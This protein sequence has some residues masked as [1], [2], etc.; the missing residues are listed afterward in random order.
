MQDTMGTPEA[1]QDDMGD[2]MRMM[3]L[4]T[5]VDVLNYAL[6]LE[7]LEFLDTASGGSGGT[8][9]RSSPPRRPGSQN[10]TSGG[11]PGR[12]QHLWEA[13]HSLPVLARDNYDDARAWRA[14][15]ATNGIDDPLRIRPGSSLYLPARSELGT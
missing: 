7:H 4:S 14:I 15:A 2:A 10:P 12:G 8:R 11:L 5:P 13:G 9:Q 1:M 3:E 6:T